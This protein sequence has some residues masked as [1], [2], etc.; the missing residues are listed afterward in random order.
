MADRRRA[1]TKKTLG[2]IGPK[3]EKPDARKSSAQA[4][5]AAGLSDTTYKRGKA[6]QD[7][8]PAPDVAAWE[9]EEIGTHAAH[10][11]TRAPDPITETL[12]HDP[13]QK[14]DKS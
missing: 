5:K 3:V 4:A 9:R 6:I 1:G 12:C 2:P 10:T 7:K 8:A 14:K 13:I 11:L